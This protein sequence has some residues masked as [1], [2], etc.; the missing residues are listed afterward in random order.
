MIVGLTGRA[1]AGKDTVAGILRERRGFVQLSFAAPMRQMVCSLLGVD[2]AEL[3]R[4]KEQPHDLFGGKTPRFAMQTLGTEWGRETIEPNLWVRCCLAAASRE[5][6]RGGSVVISDCR[7]E[8]EASAIRDAG[9][10]VL[11]I[12]RPGQAIAESAHK[13]EAGVA[14]VPGDILIENGGSLDALA[15]EVLTQVAPV[16]H[17]EQQTFAPLP[18]AGC[19]CADLT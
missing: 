4:I 14:F 6:A 7:F 12:R 5:V 19:G 1:R 15:L 17:H 9:G 11:H 13:S 3:D 18:A 8:N 2:L 16:D 10:L